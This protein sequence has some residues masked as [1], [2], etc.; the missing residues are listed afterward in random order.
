MKPLS[1]IM[2]AIMIIDKWPLI[3]GLEINI[4]LIKLQT[5]FW[6]FF[7]ARGGFKSKSLI[8][9]L[10]PEFIFSGILFYLASSLPSI[11]PLSVNAFFAA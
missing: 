9:L 4:T 7:I 1:A 8:F 2:H 10:F 5:D 6:G 11:M 3:P